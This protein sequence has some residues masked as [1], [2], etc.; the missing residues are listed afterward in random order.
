MRNKNLSNGNGFLSLE[1]QEIYFVN[2]KKANRQNLFLLPQMKDYLFI[3]FYNIYL[4]DVNSEIYEM[5]QLHSN[6]IQIRIIYGIDL[7]EKEILAV[8]KEFSNNFKKEV[9]NYKKVYE[10]N[11]VLKD[12]IKR[13][14]NLVIKKIKV[15]NYNN[16]IKYFN[17]VLR[18]KR[19]YL[20][21]KYIKI[22]N[23][24][25]VLDNNEYDLKLDFYVHIAFRHYYHILQETDYFFN[26]DYFKE[27]KP[28][29]WKEKIVKLSIEFNNKKFS[30]E[31]T[32]VINFMLGGTLFRLTIDK[33]KKCFSSLF[34]LNEEEINKLNLNTVINL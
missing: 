15:E 12:A 25:I 33:K 19:I 11:K 9:L 1:E 32:S 5:S 27:I 10:N 6:G 31:N 13:E 8:L 34:P 26:K 21:F 23:I 2:T 3:I 30:L 16:E 17:A 28:E 18:A 22:D 7:N 20:H 29:E 4:T 14:H 24:K